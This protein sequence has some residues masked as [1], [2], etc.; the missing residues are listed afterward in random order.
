MA[1]LI[2]ITVSSVVVPIKLRPALF[3]PTQP[4]IFV[5]KVDLAMQTRCHQ[6][7]PFQG[8]G[9]PT[10]VRVDRLSRL[11]IGYDQSTADFLIRGFSHGFP[12]HFEGSR[13]I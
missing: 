10:P 12:L 9:L 6:N 7:Q 3:A 13:I 8:Q 11:L 5:P 2:D 1:V 4:L